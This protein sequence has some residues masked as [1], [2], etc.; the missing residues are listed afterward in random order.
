MTGTDG[1]RNL[2]FWR[3]TA[4]TTGMSEHVP[5]VKAIVLQY[6]VNISMGHRNGLDTS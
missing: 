4:L 5:Y 3:G 6:F 2:A 1:E